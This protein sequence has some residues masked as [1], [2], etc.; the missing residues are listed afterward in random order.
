MIVKY[1]ETKIS[2]VTKKLGFSTNSAAKLYIR[3]F[4][5]AVF[6]T[7]VLLFF[8]IIAF[9]IFL[10]GCKMMWEV[11]QLTTVGKYYTRYNPQIAAMIN[12]LLYGE[13]FFLS[14]YYVVLTFLTCLI[15]CTILQ[16]FSITRFFYEPM[17]MFR[18]TLFFGI[19]IAY[20]IALMNTPAYDLVSINQYFCIAIF[21]TLMIFH[22]CFTNT[23]RFIP[24]IKDLFLFIKKQFLTKDE[25]I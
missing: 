13:L 8:A 6:T 4:I 17:G 23:T 2:S 12:E 9:Y 19:P 22:H 25:E 3:R 18:K 21:P 5:D 7:I 10:Q 11:Y 24:E 15:I 16:V 14:I 20:L 1:I